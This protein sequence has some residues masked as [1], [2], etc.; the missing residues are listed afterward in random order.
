MDAVIHSAM[1]AA[2]VAG[3]GQYQLGTG[4]DLPCRCYFD[5]S[6]QEFGEDLAPVAG[7]KRL[8]SIF[9]ADV[10][11]PQ[12]LAT[13]TLDGDVWTLKKQVAIDQSLAQWVVTNG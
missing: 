6:Q 4:A 9:L 8:L 2:G 7:A 5:E 10:P 1:T 12:R 3:S 13:V 11:N